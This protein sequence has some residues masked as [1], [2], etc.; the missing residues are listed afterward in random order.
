[1]MNRHNNHQIDNKISKFS[2]IDLSND[3][4]MTAPNY[5]Q[6]RSALAKTIGLG[7]HRGN[8]PPAP[9]P[10]APASAPAPAKPTRAPRAR[11]TA[12]AKA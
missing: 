3:Y 6:Q 1:M 10:A 12:A 5:A 11:K 7:T 4:P 2:S 9:V 8:T